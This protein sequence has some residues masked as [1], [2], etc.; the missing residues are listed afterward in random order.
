MKVKA[1][2]AEEAPMTWSLEE[3]IKWHM[4]CNVD[5]PNQYFAAVLANIIERLD[6]SDEERLVIAEL[7]TLEV[8][9]P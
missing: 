1:R 3:L 8:V 6:V 7:H 5:D 2:D 9:K 4:A